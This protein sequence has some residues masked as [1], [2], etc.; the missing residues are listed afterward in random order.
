MHRRPCPCGCGR[1][2]AL[3]DAQIRD[4]RQRT[5]Y[6]LDLVEAYNVPLSVV[7]HLKSLTDEQ[8]AA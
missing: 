1:R 7:R 2:I 4:V 6:E 5:R 3:S 8:L